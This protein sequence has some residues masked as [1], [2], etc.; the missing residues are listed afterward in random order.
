MVSC[1]GEKRNYVLSYSSHVE[2]LSVRW[3]EKIMLMTS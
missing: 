3:T 2:T 1:A